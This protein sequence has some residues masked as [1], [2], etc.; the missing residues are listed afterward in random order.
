M[1]TIDFTENL[2]GPEDALIENV[3]L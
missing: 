1:P 2:L 3:E